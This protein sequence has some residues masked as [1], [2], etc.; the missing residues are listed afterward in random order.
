MMPSGWAQAEAQLWETK[1]VWVPW[2]EL[3]GL[4][5]GSGFAPCIR[6]ACLQEPAY[7]LRQTVNLEQ[8][9]QV[10][11]ETLSSGHYSLIDI[12]CKCCHAAIG[13]Q[14]LRASN[15]VS[16][17]LQLLFPLPS[18]CN[19]FPLHQQPGE[20]PGGCPNRCSVTPLWWHDVLT[21]HRQSW[22]RMLRGTQYF[23]KASSTSL[24]C[25]GWLSLAAPGHAG[26]MLPWQLALCTSGPLLPSGCNTVPH[27][28]SNPVSCL[29]AGLIQAKCRVHAAVVLQ[30]TRQSSQEVLPFHC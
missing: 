2:Q 18:G 9:G 29:V 10:R 30:G 6:M 17:L 21:R 20:L 13:W 24:H 25:H 19:T 5:R 28:I 12:R 7:L 16:C 22:L 11:E 15:P 4:S 8:R 14:Y 3:A 23:L 1:L 26:H 27:C